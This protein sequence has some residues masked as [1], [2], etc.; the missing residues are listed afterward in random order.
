MKR[1]KL[2]K[3]KRSKHIPM[4]MCAVTREKLPKSDL[5]R[6]ALLEGKV[7][8]DRKGSIRS[9]GLNIKPDLGIF[10]LGVKK[11]V[12]SKIFNDKLDIDT[13]RRDFEQY[14]EEKYRKRKV[15]RISA[16]KLKELKG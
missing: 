2:E 1:K 3:Q 15:V 12:Y 6:I 11:R 5:V 9:R 7:V 4:R 14:L 8:V 16:D 10:D 13:L